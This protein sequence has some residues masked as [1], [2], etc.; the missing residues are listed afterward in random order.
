MRP[1]SAQSF[2]VGSATLRF[3]VPRV[4]GEWAAEAGGGRG[5]GG[6]AAVKG[7]AGPGQG[8]DSGT[9][10]GALYRRQGWEMTAGC[11][12]LAKVLISQNV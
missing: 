7:D 8:K 6:S 3:A 9:A 1:E 11:Q 2:S 12:G 4:A 10:P 5:R